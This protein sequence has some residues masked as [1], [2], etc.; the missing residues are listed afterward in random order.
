MYVASQNREGD[1]E[2][3]FAHENHAYPPSLPIYSKMRSADKSDTIKIFGNLA[4][5][6]SVKPDLTA[7]VLD[8]P[9]VVEAVVP[10]AQP[11]W[12]VLQE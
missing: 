10:K 11:I 4:E 5:A 9:A 3:S 6:S 8:G 7:E 12:A 1:L 2:E